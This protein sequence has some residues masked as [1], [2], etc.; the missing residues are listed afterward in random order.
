MLIML[1]CTC[2]IGIVLICALLCTHKLAAVVVLLGT[3]W[4]S[5]YER[6]SIYCMCTHIIACAYKVRHSVNIEASLPTCAVHKAV[7]TSQLY[8]CVHAHT[9]T[10][11]HTLI[12]AHMHTHAHTH[13]HKH[14]HTMH[15]HTIRIGKLYMCMHIIKLVW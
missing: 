13:T 1:I 2:R 10:H 3:N 15:A 14:T 12:H 11:T 8:L 9:H 4:V 6:I 5:D 7:V